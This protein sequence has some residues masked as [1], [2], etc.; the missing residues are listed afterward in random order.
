MC[1]AVSGNHAANQTSEPQTLREVVIAVVWNLQPQLLL[2]SYCRPSGKRRTSPTKASRQRDGKLSA[3]AEFEVHPYGLRRNF[4]VHVA[5][6]NP[7]F[8]LLEADIP[9]W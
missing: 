3:F 5:A 8:G 2:S 1:N 9:V 6:G 7:Y 4:C